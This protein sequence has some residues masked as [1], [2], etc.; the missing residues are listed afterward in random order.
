MKIPHNLKHCT[1]RNIMQTHSPHKTQKKYI[2]FTKQDLYSYYIKARDWDPTET[3]VMS[4]KTPLTEY[5]L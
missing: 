5:E 3:W 2:M 1:A 4:I